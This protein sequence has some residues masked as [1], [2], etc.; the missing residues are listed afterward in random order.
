MK[1]APKMEPK[2]SVASIPGIMK[3]HTFRDLVF[4]VDRLPAAIIP[5]PGLGGWAANGHAANQSLKIREL[6]PILPK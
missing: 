3:N 4:C 6:N 2:L 1:K 5:P